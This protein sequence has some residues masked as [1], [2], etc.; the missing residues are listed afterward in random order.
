[1]TV[2]KAGIADSGQRLRESDAVQLYTTVEGALADA[3]QR[4][5]E[6]NLLQVG[7]QIESLVT[8]SLQMRAE[9]DLRHLVA[10]RIGGGIKGPFGNGSDPYS[11][12]LVGNLHVVAGI[13]QTGG[14]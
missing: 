8:D 1:M 3:G 9:G 14:L 2:L 7:T 11:V 13:H 10:E 12:N 4:L 5:A 6:R